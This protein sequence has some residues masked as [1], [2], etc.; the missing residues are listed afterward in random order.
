MAEE[1]QQQA[2][3]TTTEAMAAHTVE[4]DVRN[5]PTCL[6]CSTT[7]ANSPLSFCSSTPTPLSTLVS[8]FVVSTSKPTLRIIL[9]PSS[10][11]SLLPFPFTRADRGLHQKRFRQEIWSDMARRSWEI[12]WFVLYSRNKS[13]LVLVYGEYRHREL[14]VYSE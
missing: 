7:H 13:F 14:L 3:Q 9:Q 4:K 6:S 12:I 11:S 10:R 8:R 2:I 5:S 1:M